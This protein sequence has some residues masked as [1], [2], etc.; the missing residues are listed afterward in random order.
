MSVFIHLASY[1]NNDLVPTIRDCIEKSA[2]KDSLFF[3]VCLQQDEET[4]PEIIHP[5]I[6]VHRVPWK[7]SPG[8]GWARSTAQSF[9]D[10][11]DYQLQVSA[12]S[13]FA[14]RWDEKLIA[15]LDQTGSQKPI[16]TN[17]PNK[18]NPAN[19]EREL[20]DVAFR[21][22][23]YQM[24][25]GVPMAWPFPLKGVTSI[26]PSRWIN[27][28]FLFSRGSHCSEV[29]ADPEL[30]FSE[31]EAALNLRSFCA[32]YDAFSHFIPL[33]WMEYSGKPRNW[34]EDS[35]WWLKD[36]SSKKRFSRLLDNDVPAEFGLPGIRT[37]RDFEL[38][39]GIDFKGSRLQKST[40]S[41][42]NPPCKYENEEQWNRDYMRDHVITVSWDANQIEKCD[43]YDY[44]YF[45]IEDEA[46]NNINRQDL[47]MERDASLM[48]F[49]SNF[50]KIYFKSLGGAVPSK[51]CIQPFS[52]SRGGLKMVKFD[53]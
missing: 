15:A 36:R 16:I 40:V 51:L 28:N 24:L 32:G 4:P 53:L 42:E 1:R 13:R 10:G 49:K 2:D 43:D 46:G 11:Q 52:K 23:V 38:Y 22:Q 5:R 44:W 14:D 33:V 17:F 31:C 20:P 50:K 3:G 9:Y 26:A 12:G 48:E 34:N 29:K 6:K 27:E 8:P 39:S 47:R 35:D 21:S 30:Y 41:G 25:S 45:S 19:G 7:E 18:F 37:P